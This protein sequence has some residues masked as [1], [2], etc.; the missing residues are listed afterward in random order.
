MNMCKCGKTGVDL[1]EYGC[2]Y[3]T[4]YFDE[5]KKSIKKYNY[6]FFEELVVGME[7]QGFL[8]FIKV[9]DRLHL[10]YDDVFIIRELEDKIVESLK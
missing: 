9:G 6:N 7:K 4:N 10:N 8:D 3:M 2:R 1:E 5:F